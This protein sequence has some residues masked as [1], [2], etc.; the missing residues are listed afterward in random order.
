MTCSDI[1]RTLG[2]T[3]GRF[4]LMAAAT[5]LL[6]VGLS[7]SVEATPPLAALVGGGASS[8]QTATPPEGRS[9]SGLVAR[10]PL[11]LGSEVEASRLQARLVD[12]RMGERR[13]QALRE[14]IRDLRLVGEGDV[15]DLLV[16]VDQMAPQGTYSL[17]VDI[18]RSLITGPG[19]SLPLDLELEIPRGELSTAEKVTL[20]HVRG[21]TPTRP[22]LV[23]VE[24]GGQTTI[25]PLSAPSEVALLDQHSAP[26]GARLAVRLPDAVPA[27]GSA[28]YA[29][30]VEGI[31]PLGT[32]TASFAIRSAQL[33]EPKTVSVTVLSRRSGLCL[34]LLI[35]LGVSTGMLIREVLGPIVDRS[36]A[37]IHSEGV[38]SQIAKEK[39]AKGD[40]LFRSEVDELE[41]RLRGALDGTPLELVKASDA[42]REDLETLLA[43][44]ESRMA[45]ARKRRANLVE[46]LRVAQAEDL[47]EALTTLL[48]AAVSKLDATVGEMGRAMFEDSDAKH[49][50]I[51]EETA[52]ALRGPVE[53]WAQEIEEQLLRQRWLNSG[54]AESQRGLFSQAKTLE[55]ANKLVNDAD[56]LKLHE[57]LSQ[58]AELFESFRVLAQHLRFG[59]VTSL[60]EALVHLKTLGPDHPE[61]VTFE[62]L[63][64]RFETEMQKVATPG[65]VFASFAK[66]HRALDEALQRAILSLVGDPE[67]RKLLS[68]RLAKGKYAAEL[69]RLRAESDAEEPETRVGIASKDISTQSEASDGPSLRTPTTRRQRTIPVDAEATPSVAR[70]LPVVDLALEQRKIWAVRAT[71]FGVALVVVAAGGYFLWEPE[72]VGTARQCFGVFLWGYGLDVGIDKAVEATAT[73]AKPAR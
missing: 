17:V 4:V 22:A 39:A 29:L 21:Q 32:S 12:V 56:T 15:V 10:F 53:R 23:L 71:Q 67:E 54:L 31:L 5:A 19:R 55:A 16:E 63:L 59:V 20:R 30:D 60:V 42:A 68:Q 9:S 36:K 26:T 2:R 24:T 57:L 41:R 70:S 6:T 58:S 46:T 50:V 51:E 25:H 37:N 61:V 49:R 11:R 35:A 47:P 44:L 72:W 7:P 62:K 69:R 27:G 52:D 28:S 65:G 13:D 1:P 64:T 73:L 40:S 43:G 14:L 38:R 45:A 3:A 18:I 66:N 48:D 34:L 33:E 8:V